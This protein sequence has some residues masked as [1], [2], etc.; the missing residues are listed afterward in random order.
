MCDLNST[1]PSL[2]LLN[3]DFRNGPTEGRTPQYAPQYQVKFGTK[4][5]KNDRIKL[6]VLTTLVDDHFADDDS[7][8]NRFVP[9]YKVW[10]LSGEIVIL[11]NIAG[12]FDFSLFGGVNNLFNENYWARVTSAGIDPA[13][14]RNYY[15]GVK[16]SVGIPS[17][18]KNETATPAVAYGV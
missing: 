13:F 3:A 6:S 10:D 14:P 16:I 1:P 11:K 5:N 8:P 9:Y 15:G 2:T 17:R 4:Y 18:E 7:T 12:V